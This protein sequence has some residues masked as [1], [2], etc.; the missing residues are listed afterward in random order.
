MLTDTL[1]D[2]LQNT[3]QDIFP[4]AGFDPRTIANLGAWYDAKDASTIT[5][6]SGNVSQWRDKSGNTRHIGQSTGAIQP[7]YNGT[8]EI[9]FSSGDYLIN[10]SPFMFAAGSL[11]MYT[12]VDNATTKGALFN[13][14]NQTLVSPAYMPFG[15]AGTNIAFIRNDAGQTR[16]SVI[17]DGLFDDGN[18]HLIKNIDT[19][20][21]L[22]NSV[23]GTE[24]LNNAYTRFG[25]FTLN[26][27]ALGSLVRNSPG[28]YLV[29]GV[30]EVL[31][32]T[33]VLT[34]SEQMQVEAY[35]SA[36]WGL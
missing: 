9:F 15:L 22:T 18:L 24:I 28:Q 36:K 30:K 19:G 5:E 35:L 1:K 11:T 8:D 34:A 20:S 26:Q 17:G 12:V 2:T 21:N 3:L 13:E 27:F 25:D 23:D 6:S 14:S 33:R 29:G 10:S 4:S 32:Y 16:I 7:N 31:I